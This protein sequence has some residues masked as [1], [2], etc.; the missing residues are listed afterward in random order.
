MEIP[1]KLGKFFFLR[2]GGWISVLT[3]NP[4]TELH[5]YCIPLRFELSVARHN[6]GRLNTLQLSQFWCNKLLLTNLWKG[7]MPAWSVSQQPTLFSCEQICFPRSLWWRHISGRPLCRIIPLGSAF[8]EAFPFSCAAPSLYPCWDCS[9]FSLGDLNA[10]SLSLSWEMPSVVASSQS[11]SI[12]HTD[13]SQAATSDCL[14]MG[15]K[16]EWYTGE[17][18]I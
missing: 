13:K 11:S 4:I 6:N 9:P 8:M 3:L 18:G 10:L 14:L 7:P 16:S 12:V 2:L 15:Q 5:I 1:Q 17:S